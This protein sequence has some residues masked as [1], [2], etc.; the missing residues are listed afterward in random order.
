MVLLHRLS[1]YVPH[2]IALAASSPWVQG[3]DTGFASSRLN[4]VQAFPLSGRAPLLPTWSAFEDHFNRLARTGIVS[5]MKDFYWDVRPKPEFGTVEVRVMDTPLTLE[6]AAALAGFIQCLSRWCLT[7]GARE[8]REDD[9]LPYTY[10]R[11]QAARFG[12]DGRLADAAGGELVSVR[13]SLDALLPALRA[14]AQDL[15]ADTALDEVARVLRHG[16]DSDRL[17]P[18]RSAGAAL[19]EVVAV[20]RSLW[21]GDR[22]SATEPGRSRRPPMAFEAAIG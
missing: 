9:L 22:A 11:F 20:Q 5:S 10:N 1:L 6:R 21:R 17:R 2:L 16:N 19:T 4:T 13:D 15:G 18:L 14:H 3:V 7:D 8:V 12:L